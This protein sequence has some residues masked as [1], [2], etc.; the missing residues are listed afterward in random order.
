MLKDLNISKKYSCSKTI[1]ESFIH[2]A[3][4]RGSGAKML[5]LIIL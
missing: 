5:I 1:E 4:R 3:L 2:K